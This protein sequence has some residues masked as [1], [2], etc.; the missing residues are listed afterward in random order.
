MEVLEEAFSQQKTPFLGWMG[1]KCFIV[2]DHPDDVQIVMNS[3]G[4][5]EKSHVYRFFNRGVGLFTAPGAK[6]FEFC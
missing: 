5:I 2:I 4:C 3:K 6:F 1:P